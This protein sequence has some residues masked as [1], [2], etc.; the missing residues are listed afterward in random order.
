MRFIPPML[1]TALRD[2]RRVS[3][4]RYIAEPKFDG[5]RAQV[6][7]AAWKVSLGVFEARERRDAPLAF[8]TFG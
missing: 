7:V 4:P 6:H 1:C 3:D 8:V 5:Q 2:P